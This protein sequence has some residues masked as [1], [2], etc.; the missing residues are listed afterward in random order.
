MKLKLFL[1]ETLAAAL[2]T[3]SAAAA[4]P[5]EDPNTHVVRGNIFDT[6]D[7]K[8]LIFTFERQPFPSGNSLRVM[9][10]YKDTAGNVVAT[11]EIF[12]ENG[13]VT[14]LVLDQKQVDE[15]GG[16]EIKGDKIL[17]NYTK[18]GKTETDEEKLEEP[19]LVADT[20][21]AF[22]HANWD[23][24]MN[25]DSLKVRL[26]VPARLETIGFKF[27]KDSDG[28]MDGKPVH[29]IKMSASSP[30]VRMIVNPLFFSI[31]KGEAKTVHRV[32]GRI[33]PKIK[34]DGKWA[35]ADGISVFTHEFKKK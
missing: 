6:K 23:K 18:N 34:K 30:F 32:V 35:D 20:V 33:S 4:V 10:S 29:M 9:R 13:K 17:F 8:K 21:A 16:F 24:L 27:E 19:L 22:I 15:K 2:L 25:G 11:E 5:L 14:K 7:E 1:F 28:V 31:D 12:Y 26:P 3:I